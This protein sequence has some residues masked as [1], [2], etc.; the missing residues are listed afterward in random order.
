MNPVSAG[1][2]G[3]LLPREIFDQIPTLNN[4][5]NGQEALY[6]SELKVIG[7]R[8]DP[9]SLNESSNCVHEVR[10]VWQPISFDTDS[11][12]WYTQD[13]AIHTFYEIGTAE[14]K[15]LITHLRKFKTDNERVNIK[16]NLVPL[17]VHPAFLNE[18]K[19]F[20][21]ADKLNSILLK[22]CGSKN[23]KK[24]TFMR[25]LTQ[26]IWWRFGGIE[27][28][29]GKWTQVM[30]PRLNMNFQDIFNS[31]LE[32]YPPIHNPGTAMDA[33]FNIMPANY[34]AEDDLFT[35]INNGVRTNTD[36]DFE[37]FKSKIAAT[38]RFKN[39]HRTNPKTLDC[40]SCHFANATRFY[41]NSRFNSLE[42]FSSKDNY[43]NPDPAHFNL[44]NN[45]IA[46]RATRVVR[47]FGYFAKEPAISQRV[48]NDS[49]ESAHWLNQNNF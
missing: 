22:F 4:S 2:K 34:P 38:E 12:V 1:S 29:E 28:T 17:G 30:I 45:S 43:N 5:G 35:V 13:A 18:S 6:I 15:N 31:A 36:D 3:K 23:L 44:I 46:S 24:V 8:I 40:A 33:V 26:N 14:F 39:P 7:V 27:L 41:I 20:L 16:T 9:C 25:L 19:K 48:I 10:L 37:E 11:L 21:Q 47:A 49:A 42:Q 32:E